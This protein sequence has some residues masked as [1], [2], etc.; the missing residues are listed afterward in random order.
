MRIAY[1]WQAITVAIT[2]SSLCK[3]SFLIIR[4]IWSNVTDRAIMCEDLVNSPNLE[5]RYI[6]YLV[7]FLY[8]YL[9]IFCI[10]IF[11][12][13]KRSNEKKAFDKNQEST[14]ARRNH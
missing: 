10:S 9:H 6:C 12:L 1:Y 3:L 2:I 14:I 4:S 7:V 5:Y 8:I 11:I 13:R